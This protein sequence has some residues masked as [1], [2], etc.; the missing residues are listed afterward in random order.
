MESLDQLVYRIS[1]HIE[2]CRDGGAHYTIKIAHVRPVLLVKILERV[3]TRLGL[4]ERYLWD[5]VHWELLN[6]LIVWLKWIKVSL[7]LAQILVEVQIR[8]HVLYHELTLVALL[9]LISCLDERLRNLNYSL[10]FDVDLLHGPWVKMEL[11]WTQ[12]CLAVGGGPCDPLEVLAWVL[13]RNH[14]EHILRLISLLIRV[15]E[16]AEVKFHLDCL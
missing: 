12:A 10:L 14:I 3:H 9:K 5:L 1:L 13:F 7:A 2:A 16:L 15:I 4:W 6:L 8:L 11:I